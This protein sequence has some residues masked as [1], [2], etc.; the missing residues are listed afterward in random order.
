M[1]ISAAASKLLL[2]LL[3][4]K[5]AADAAPF[6]YFVLLPSRQII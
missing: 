6:P 4:K 1:T 2:F 3:S 5:G